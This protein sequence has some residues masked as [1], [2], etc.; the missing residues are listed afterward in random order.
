MTF[1]LA[2]PPL[3]TALAPARNVLIA[4]AG[5]GFDVYAGLPLAFALQSGGT[6]VHLAWSTAA[7]TSSCAATKVT[8]AHPSRT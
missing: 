4:G 5:G 1:A 6:R 3:F 7:P 2:A 8:W